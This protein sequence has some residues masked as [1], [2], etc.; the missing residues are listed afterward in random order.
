[1]GVGDP[2]YWDLLP[3]EDKAAY[4]RLKHEFSVGSLRRGPR[5]HS[6]DTFDG[7]L[8]AIREFAERDDGNDWRRF[9]VCGV[10]WMDHAIAINTRQLRLLVSKCKSSINGSL[11]KMGYATNLSHG[12]SWKAL[13]PHIPIL[14]DHFSELRQWTIRYANGVFR[15]PPPEGDAPASSEIAPS[16]VPQKVPAFPLKFRGRLARSDP[17]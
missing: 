2:Q 3:D 14:K 12:E 13:F 16:P 5:S 7:M 4:N 17:V 15:S 9:L 6:A 11:Q 1:M 8:E 10:C